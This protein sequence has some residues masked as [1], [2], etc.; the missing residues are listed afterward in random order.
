[1]RHEVFFLDELFEEGDIVGREE[2]LS[3][4]ASIALTIRM[5]TGMEDSLDELELTAVFRLPKAGSSVA[6][7]SYEELVSALDGD[8]TLLTVGKFR[9]PMNLGSK[10][11][12]ES[13][14]QWVVLTFTLATADQRQGGHPARP[15]LEKRYRLNRILIYDIL[16]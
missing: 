3:K 8:F 6:L 2:T 13:V 9:P 1:L 7:S 14:L 4:R 10:S 5:G 11:R 15:Y 12:E 16:E